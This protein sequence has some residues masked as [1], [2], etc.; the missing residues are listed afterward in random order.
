MIEL[1]IIKVLF[2]NSLHTCIFSQ[3]HEIHKISKHGN[4]ELYDMLRETVS[5]YPIKYMFVRE[6]NRKVFG[7][8]SL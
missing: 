1:A 3:F 2:P 6:D 8:E 5:Q 4:L 7:P